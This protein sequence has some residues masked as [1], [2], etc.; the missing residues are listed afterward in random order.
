MATI[1]VG[2]FIYSDVI[3]SCGPETDSIPGSSKLIPTQIDCS[4]VCSKLNECELNDRF[5]QCSEDCENSYT[6]DLKDCIFDKECEEIELSCF[7]ESGEITDCETICGILEQCAEIPFEGCMTECPSFDPDK[8]DCI[9]NTDC[10]SIPEVCFEERKDEQCALFCAQLV[11]C[12]IVSQADQWNCESMCQEEGQELINCVL[13]S[14]C[15]KVD[16]WCFGQTPRADCGMFCDHLIECG[17]W[18]F[19]DYALCMEECN[20]EPQSLVDC[21]IESECMILDICYE[22]PWPEPECTDYCDRLGQCG[23]LEPWDFVECLEDCIDES[24]EN[25]WCVMNT[26]CVDIG[27]T[28]WDN[29][30]PDSC[31][32]ACD[33]MTECGFE[34]PFNECF[35]ICMDLWSADTPACVLENSCGELETICFETTL[36]GD[37]ADVCEK[38]TACGLIKE[39]ENCIDNCKESW[40]EDKIECVHLM[41]CDSIPA[42]CN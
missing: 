7:S 22:N 28:C 11:E 9:I 41:P 2:V 30:Y 34:L 15:E 25:L 24:A 1:F 14:P 33:K 18:E 31:E 6:L 35:T 42:S 4:I 20:L 10:D 12:E 23:I 29:P 5:D 8:T 27:S 16:R 39:T 26:P 38:M 32:N 3:N 40:T 21:V 17:N 13:G 36:E 19:E 37:C